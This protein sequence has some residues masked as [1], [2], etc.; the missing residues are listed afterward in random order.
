MG[1][2]VSLKRRRIVGRSNDQNTI[3]SLPFSI[4]LRMSSKPQQLT[5]RAAG[6]ANLESGQASGSGEG[7]QSFGAD[8]GSEEE[9]L[10]LDD[11]D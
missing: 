2:L 11:F 8:G 7:G 3:H 10:R 1:L 6:P 4:H 5:E 9:Y